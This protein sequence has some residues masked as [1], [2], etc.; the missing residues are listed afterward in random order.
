MEQIK[1][2]FCHP[3]ANIQGFIAAHFFNYFIIHVS[4][5]GKNRNLKKWPNM[6]P[7]L[8]LIPSVRRS[9]CV[10]DHISLWAIKSLKLQAV[11]GLLTD[12]AQVLLFPSCVNYTPGFDKCHIR[13]RLLFPARP[14]LF[15]PPSFLKVADSRYV[16]YSYQNCQQ[17]VARNMWFM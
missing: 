10:P 7:R 2:C 5:R 13:H 14:A 11:S 6:R 15:R 4:I 8:N 17:L 1:W 9:V 12:R 3:N 16:I